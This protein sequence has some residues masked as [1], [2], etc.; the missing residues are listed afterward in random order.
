MHLRCFMEE[1]RQVKESRQFLFGERT[2]EQKYHEN[3]WVSQRVSQDFR[4]SGQKSVRPTAVKTH[5]VK[6]DKNTYALM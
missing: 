4:L 5:R 6:V 1:I 3:K 2:L